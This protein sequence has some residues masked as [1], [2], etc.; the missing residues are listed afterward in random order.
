MMIFDLKLMGE[1]V[2]PVAIETPLADKKIVSTRIYTLSGVQ[3]KTPV[4]GVNIIKNI[5]SDGTVDTQKVIIK[6]R[7]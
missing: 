5:Y 1:G 4:Y 7:Y 2:D 3:V 6:E